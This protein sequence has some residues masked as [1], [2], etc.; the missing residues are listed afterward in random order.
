MMKQ[1]YLLS[2][3]CALFIFMIGCSNGSSPVIPLSQTDQI[4]SPSISVESNPAGIT[5]AT[6]IMGAY[7]LTIDP[8]NMTADLVPK[9]T[10]AIGESYT[11]SGLSYFTIKP[12]G[13][14]LQIKGIK[15]EGM[16]IL[17]QF[18][19]KHPFEKGDTGQPPSGKN[20]LDLDVFDLSLVVVPLNRL[21]RVYPKLETFILDGICINPDGYTLDLSDIAGGMVAVPYYLAVDDEETG[22]NT[23]NKFE[24]GTTSDL[25]V[26]LIL[27][28]TVLNY[29]L[30][31]TMGYGWSAKWQDRLNPQ[32]F[33]PEFNKKSAWKV[34]ARQLDYWHDTDS[35]TAVIV[36]VEVYDWQFAAVVDPTLSDPSSV[37]AS[38]EVSQVSVEIPGMN[39]SLQSLPGNNYDT[40]T[41]APNDPLIYHIPIKNENLLPKGLYKGLVKVTD[42]RAPMAV[43]PTGDRDFMVHS[44]DGG[45]TLEYHP[46]PQYATYQTFNASVVSAGGWARTWGGVNYDFALGV[47]ID[48][49]DQVYVTGTFRGLVDFDPSP[50]GVENRTSIGSQD[51]FLCKFD[52]EGNYLWAI[53]WGG[54]YYTQ[55]T[56]VF[57]DNTG[58]IAVTGIF[59]DTVDFDPSP[60]GNDVQ[61]SNGSTDCFLSWYDPEGNHIEVITWGGSNGEWV[62]GFDKDPSGNIYVAGTFADSVDLNPGPG[63]DIHTSNGQG[64]CFVMSLDSAFNFRWAKSWGGTDFDSCTTVDADYPGKIYC[65]GIFQETVDFDP[66]AGVE[67]HTSLGNWDIYLST[68]NSNGDF[69]GVLV[70]GGTDQEIAW[71]LESNSVGDVYVVG[72]F[73]GTSDFDP[74]LGVDNRTAPG[75]SEDCFMS[76]FDS[77]GVYQWVYTWGDIINDS[78][79]TICIDSSDNVIVGG[80]YS[81]KVDFDPSLP[82]IVEL[83]AVAGY[84]IFFSKFNAL[85]GFQWVRGF[86]GSWFDDAL[87]VTTDSSDNLYG[88]G[89]FSNT[90]DFNP[91]PWGLDWH[92]SAGE[93]DAFLLKLLP[94]GEWQ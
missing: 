72:H 25:E 75:G 76:K 6:G 39:T 14:C 64:D 31:L 61:T 19:V 13:D 35:T 52:P 62:S 4:D 7:E 88:C 71:N 20:R 46:L 66:G 30:Y 9:R 53:S 79:R 8:E 26:Y 56:S 17:M 36:E 16:G 59:S 65:T 3:A 1:K 49:L 47:C 44:P 29:D 89:D 10:L 57:F 37:Y 21:Y 73:F 55:A 69:T 5:G 33:N 83:T 15:W 82:G 40:G 32:Y 63:V 24:M 50:D 78:C 86:G 58:N 2:T 28:S 34:K 94:N 87:Y 42:E 27:G 74:G 48:D 70:W 91:D 11:V 60:N 81:G 93:Y 90:V 12:C 85:D 68:F 38:S 18:E 41:G 45:V 43:P 77:S 84:D 67:N 80:Y 23:F 51:A 92:S 54:I 22:G